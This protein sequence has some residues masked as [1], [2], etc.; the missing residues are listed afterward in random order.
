MAKIARKFMKIFGSNAGAQE[1]G[2]FG[3]LAAG[4]PAY[5]TDPET[6]QSLSNYEDGWY[7]AVLG[8]N[9][10][11]IQDMNALQFLF[12]YQLTYGFQAGVAEWDDAT[13]YY[14]GSL[15]QDGS[16]NLYKSIADNNTNNALSDESKWSPYSSIPVGAM[17]EYLGSTAPRGWVLASGKTIGDGSS[18]GTARANADTLALFTLLWTEYANTILVIQDSS[19]TPTT[20]GASAAA[21]FAAHK[22][23]P[24]PDLRGR[25]PAGLDN[26]GGSAAS[27]L[28]ATTM[29]PDGNTLGASGGA[30]THTLDTTQIPSHTH[31]QNAHTHA[32]TDPT[33]GH[34]MAGSNFQGGVSNTAARADGSSVLSTSTAS[35]T[36]I[37]IQ[38]TT[39]TNQNTGGGG[40]HNNVQPTWLVSYI[41]KL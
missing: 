10:P 2:V 9:S 13:I 8:N 16:G 40:A 19:G 4:L 32:V 15:A 35:S 5:T 23:M 12:A 27:R 41:I 22:R 1:R 3:S 24:L 18:G 29:T 11:A 25:V 7:G 38:N 20:R 14:I 34:N 28:T 21:D 31:T 33:H 36:G 39:A 6:I 26:M 17:Q 30:Q 37:S